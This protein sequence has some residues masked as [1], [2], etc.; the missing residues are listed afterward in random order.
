MSKKLPENDFTWVEEISHFNKYFKKSYNDEKDERYLFEADIQY[1]ENLH[2]FFNNLLV[3]PERI[4][5]KKV[6][7]LF[8]T[9]LIKN[10]ILY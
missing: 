9:F 7:K 10:N 1:S 8:Q 6:K 5:L 4:K 3:L 2:N